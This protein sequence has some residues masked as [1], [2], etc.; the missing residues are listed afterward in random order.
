MIFGAITVYFVV[1][2]QSAYP[3]LVVILQKVFKMKIDYIDPNK[4]PY[5]NFTHFS[6]SYIAI[7]EFCKFFV[8]GMKKDLS[9]FVK[10]GFLG[11]CCVILMSGVVIVYGIISMTDTSFKMVTTPGE[12]ATGGKLWQDPFNDTQDLILFNSGFPNLSGVLCSGYFMHQFA[13]PIIT[14]AKEP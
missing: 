8:F 14:N 10:L 6:A 7:F 3:I 1:V 9:I 5:Y 4:P 11:S 2:V 13:I 12:S